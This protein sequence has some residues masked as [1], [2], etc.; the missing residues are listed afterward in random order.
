M[1]IFLAYYNDDKDI[2]EAV[3]LFISTLNAAIKANPGIVSD[4]KKAAPQ[5]DKGAPKKTKKTPKKDK[6]T[7]IQ[8][9]SLEHFPEDVRLIR[10][11]YNA[12][13][14]EK[15]RRAL[16]LMFRDF[17]KRATER[18]VNIKKPLF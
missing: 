15:T 6:E 8:I 16:L 7:K 9:E 11:V 18:K 5:K 2:K 17:E 3:D 14:K 10:R 13:G 4:T 12:I 1:A